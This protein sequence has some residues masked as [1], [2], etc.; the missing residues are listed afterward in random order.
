MS[1][2]TTE[3]IGSDIQ[4]NLTPADPPGNP[5]VIG[6]AGFVVGSVA[7]GLQLSGYVSAGAGAAILPIIFGSSSAASVI[8]TLWAARLGQNAV[9]AVFG[10]FT[11]FWTSYTLLVMGLTKGWL[12]IPPADIAH[13]QALFVISWLVVVVALTIGSVRLPSSFTLVFAL[14]DI[15]FV[16]QLVG[17][18]NANTTALKY[19]GYSTLA[20]ALIGFYLFLDAFNQA[21][22]GKP[23]PIGSPLVT[24]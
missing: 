21:T 8:A 24:A 1:T 6:L 16:L 13:T 9:A 3:R 23:L 15:T 11:G 4:S 20:F 10:V 22:G 18:L 2:A 17:V 19:S 12:A 5:M 7:L 14:V